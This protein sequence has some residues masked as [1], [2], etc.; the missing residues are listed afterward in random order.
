MFSSDTQ[1]LLGIC[2]FESSSDYCTVNSSLLGKRPLQINGVGLTGT[3]VDQTVVMK[4]QIGSTS[5]A[6]PGPAVTRDFAF[7]SDMSKGVLY[8]EAPSVTEI[9]GTTI[10]SKVSSLDSE[11][12]IQGPLT[13]GNNA[14]YN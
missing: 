10:G 11:I 12:Y 7:R 5:M 13:N 1:K 9:L 14:F 6:T 3:P 4:Y 2:N 8:Y